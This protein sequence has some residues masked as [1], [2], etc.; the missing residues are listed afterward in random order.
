MGCGFFSWGRTVWSETA[1]GGE[2]LD[3]DLNLEKESI[4]DFPHG[5]VVKTLPSTAGDVGLIPGQGTKISHAMWCGQGK[6]KS[7][8]G[9]AGEEH[10]RCREQQMQEL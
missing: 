9:G 3:K 2:Y 1:V 6:K 10:H 8:S 4:T 5:P 7:I